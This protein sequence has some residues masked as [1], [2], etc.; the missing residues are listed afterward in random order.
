MR[1]GLT[2]NVWE[3]VSGVLT[4]AERTK[5]QA[6]VTDPAVIKQ[7]QDDYAYATSSGSRRRRRSW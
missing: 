6:L 2:G 3:T 1:W 5:V 7:V 4:A